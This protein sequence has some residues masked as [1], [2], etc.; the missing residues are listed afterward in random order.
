MIPEGATE[1]D[2]NTRL[3]GP[4]NPITFI[5]I[6][7]KRHPIMQRNVAQHPPQHHLTPPTHNTI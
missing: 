5:T 1:D 6:I 4:N 2:L 7:L 3:K